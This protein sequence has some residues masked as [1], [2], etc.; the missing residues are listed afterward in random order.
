M[1][2]TASTNTNNTNGKKSEKR[3]SPA[4]HNWRQNVLGDKKL[5][6]I[7]AVLHLIAAPAVILAMIIS[8]PD[9]KKLTLMLLS[10]Q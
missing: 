3:L 5:F 9:R 4:L 7:L 2:A 10:V 8:V 1:T 6:I